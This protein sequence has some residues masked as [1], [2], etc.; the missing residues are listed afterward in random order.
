[1][2][3]VGAA[4][5][6]DALFVENAGTR[7]LAAKR[8]EIA[9]PASVE[10]RG[11][12]MQLDFRDEQAGV[13]TGGPDGDFPVLPDD[14]PDVADAAGLGGRVIRGWK[15]RTL[16]QDLGGAIRRDGFEA[17]RRMPRHQFE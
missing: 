12:L 6:G 3:A 10:R 4:S 8:G 9:V 7:D 16:S 5:R 14:F 15:F 17:A 11:L 2:E 1:V 13:A